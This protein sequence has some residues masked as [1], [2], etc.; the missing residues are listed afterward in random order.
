METPQGKIEIPSNG[1]EFPSESKEYTITAECCGVSPYLMNPFTKELLES[2]RCKI[3][4]VRAVDQ[5]PE[6]EA[7]KKLCKKNGLYGFPSEYLFSCILEAGRYVK[8]GK[9][10][11][12]TKES[13]LIPSFLAI[14]ENFLAFP[15][16]AKW[17]VD[18]RRGVNPN[19]GNPVC[20][21]RP[22][23][24]NWSFKCTLEIDGSEIDEY[25][26]RRLL[27]I[28]GKKIGLGDFTPSHRGPFGRFQIAKWESTNGNSKNLT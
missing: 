26:V 2:M 21:V 8:P 9:T 6:Q 25:T 22:R 17:E 13:S 11:L 19:D 23:F 10:Q 14:T 5:T 4:I 24:D 12:S 18:M 3:P 7:S 20:I 28:A 1:H 27:H 16:D 15:E